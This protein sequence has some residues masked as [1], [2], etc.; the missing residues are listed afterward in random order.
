MV[1]KSF[2]FSTDNIVPWTEVEADQTVIFK[3]GEPTA[4]SNLDPS[5]LPEVRV[6]V[7]PIRGN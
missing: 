7:K 4:T 2:K 1:A 3:P 6:Q 5:K